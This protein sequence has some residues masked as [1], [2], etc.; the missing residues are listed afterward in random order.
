MKPTTYSVIILVLLAEIHLLSGFATGSNTLGD[1]VLSFESA[2]KKIVERHVG[3]GIQKEEFERVKSKNRPSHLKLLPRFDLSAS[4]NP[5]GQPNIDPLTSIAIPNRTL[6]MQGQLNLYHFGADVA[7][8]RYATAQEM[9]E[10]V[11][12]KDAEIWAEMQGVESIIAMIQFRKQVEVTKRDMESKAEAV[13]SAEKLFRKGSVPQG[14]VQKATIELNTSRASLNGIQM[15]LAQAR[16]HLSSLLGDEYSSTE[17][18]WKKRFLRFSKL[19]SGLDEPDLSRRPDWTAAKKNE[20]A[21]SE[22]AK[23]QWGKV[24]PSLD[25]VG[26]L[27]VYDFPDRGARTLGIVELRLSVP[28][29]DRLENYGNYE[30]SVHDTA[31]ASLR[32][33]GIKRQARREW[34]ANREAFLRTLEMAKI[35][36]ETVAQ[37]EELYEY[38]DS[39]FRRG[40]LSVDDV[41]RDQE[42]ILK[43]EMLAIQNWGEI[44]LVFAK[45]CHSA[46]YRIA[47]CL[48]L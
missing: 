9:S 7:E 18:P 40:R 37:S 5:R 27:G 41:A 48:A 2:I 1:D 31:R 47:A 20:E 16:A 24:M 35:Q 42:R 29:F 34:E 25:L 43:A 45:L 33:E 19:V 22:K 10:E 14:E 32:F 46:G 23:A 3:V 21:M 17:W 36:D 26:S 13:A 4:I 15:K 30:A 39:Q 6:A 8:K 28:V 38:T 11:L 12:I 44:H